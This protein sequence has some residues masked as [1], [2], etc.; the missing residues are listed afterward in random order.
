MVSRAKAGC[1][2]ELG[3]RVGL[4]SMSSGRD[5]VR[6]AYCHPHVKYVKSVRLEKLVMRISHNLQSKGSLYVRWSGA[7]AEGG[8]GVSA[9]V[10]RRASKLAGRSVMGPNLGVYGDLIHHDMWILPLV[11]YTGVLLG[12]G[13]LTLAIGTQVAPTQSSSPFST[14]NPIDQS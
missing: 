6:A 2:D 9:L 13:F 3:V 4:Y 7:E 1:R 14:K 11:G 5:M 10:R 12:F 8:V